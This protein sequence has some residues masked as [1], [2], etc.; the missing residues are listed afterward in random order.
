MSSENQ[1]YLFESEISK[2][3]VYALR[4]VLSLFSSKKLKILEIGSWSGLGSTKVFAEY[5][6]EIVCV[7]TWLGNN[8]EHHN[9]A[10]KNIDPYQAF[11]QNTADFNDKVRIIKKKSDQ[12][13]DE[14]SNEQSEYLGISQ[15]GPFKPGYYRY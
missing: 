7:D 9:N 4:K 10:I 2:Y 3:D 12:A 6:R 5:S 15:E 11:M 1:N 8:V 13:L 14:L